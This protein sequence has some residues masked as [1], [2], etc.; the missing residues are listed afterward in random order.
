MALGG[1][2]CH[3]QPHSGHGSKRTPPWDFCLE[4]NHNFLSSPRLSKLPRAKG[5]LYYIFKCP[6][7]LHVHTAIWKERGILTSHESP[8]KHGSEISNLLKTVN[9]ACEVAVI[10]YKWNQ[11]AVE[12]NSQGNSKTNS[13]AKQAALQHSSNPSIALIIR[14]W[15]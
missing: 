13:T 4:A 15:F 14:S 5:L 12:S 9:F 10:H 7:L 1:W 8:I 3:S 2:L 6:F 11:V